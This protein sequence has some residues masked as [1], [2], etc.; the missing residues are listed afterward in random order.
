M[1]G[2]RY[3]S[4]NAFSFASSVSS[5]S[6]LSSAADIGLKAMTDT[7]IDASLK[8]AVSAIEKAERELAAAGLQRQTDIAVCINTGVFQITLSVRKKD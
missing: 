2:V 4:G 6:S 8:S 1:K 7:A 3:F 5:L